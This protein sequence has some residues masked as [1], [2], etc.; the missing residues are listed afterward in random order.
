MGVAPSRRMTSLTSPFS[1][2]GRITPRPFRL[3]VLGVYLLSFLSQVLLSPPVTVQ[4]SIM[5]FAI[6]QAL[7]TWI[8]YV[9]HVRRLRDAGRPAG[10]ASAIAVLYALAMVL[11]MLLAD[12]IIGP[13]VSAVGTNVPRWSFND[14][15]M[16]FL[17]VSALVAQASFDFFDLLALA[18]LV[19][20]LAP[21]VIAIAFSIWA[22]TRPSAAS[23]APA[24]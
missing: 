17:L 10:A 23:P 8:W 7:L 19:L 15:W 18:I 3:A 9:L 22:A 4:F 1:V 14:V 24:L 16:F 2:S 20:I 5:P 11:L 13:D 6:A 12:P 21:V